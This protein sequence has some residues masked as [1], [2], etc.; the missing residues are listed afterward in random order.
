MLVITNTMVSLLKLD[1]RYLL[2]TSHRPGST[3]KRCFINDFVALSLGVCYL[4]K[5]DT[6]IEV[7][8]ERHIYFTTVLL[9]VWLVTVCLSVLLKDREGLDQWCAH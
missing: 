5:G 8:R 3:L 1:I 9:S 2:F 6:L 4:D 7:W